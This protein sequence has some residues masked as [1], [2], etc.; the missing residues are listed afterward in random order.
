MTIIFP[1]KNILTD[2]V[3]N[4]K[5]KDKIYPYK[6]IVIISHFFEVR[7]SCSLNAIFC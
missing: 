4:C 5:I 6:R 1:Y 3:I 2:I 7:K